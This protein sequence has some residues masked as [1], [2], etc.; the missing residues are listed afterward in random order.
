LAGRN[1]WTRIQTQKIIA[2]RRFSCKLKSRQTK[3]YKMLARA[4][5]IKQ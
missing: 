4:S 3:R 5:I 1:T 2:N